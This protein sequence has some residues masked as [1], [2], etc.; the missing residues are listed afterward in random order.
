[1]KL[2]LAPYR[3]VL[4][5]F[6]FF[7]ADLL[8]SELTVRFFTLGFMAGFPGY[9]ILFSISIAFIFATIC[10]AL[11]P[12]ARKIVSF[13]ISSLAFII[14]AVQLVYH[15]FCDAFMS[16]AQIGMGGAALTTFGAAAFLK[17]LESLGGLILLILP[18][19][20]LI[21]LTKKGK[22]TGEKT[23]FK[24]LLINVVLFFAL[25]F[26][27]VLCLPIVGTH[28]YSPFDIYHDTFVLEKS[29]K[30][31][32][33]LSTLRLEIRTI[34]F[35]SSE[36]ELI[37][38]PPVT[39]E[40]DSSQTSEN[41]QTSEITE[42]TEPYQ[43]EE[44]SPEEKYGLNQS[45]IDFAKLA[46]S[47][48]DEDIKLLHTYFD[49]IQPTNKNEYTGMFEG[50]NLILIN[51]ESFSHHVIDEER[52]PMLYKMM[53]EGFIFTDYYNTICD[54]TSNGEY[55]LLT[56]LIPDTSLLGKGWKT[57]YN[58]NSSTASKENLLP[59]C[60]GNQFESIG[61]DA[62]AIHNH[63]ASYYGRNKTHP[64]MGYEFI[65]FKQ[66]LKVVDTYPTSDVSMMEQALP[67]LLEP[68]ENGEIEQFH[69]YFLTFS[70]HM[71][72]SFSEEYNDIAAK[73]AP[74]VA[75]LSYSNK[76][77]AYVACQLE[78]EFAVEYLVEQLEAAGVLDKT[79]I[80][81]TN[82]HYPYPLGV[83]LLGELAEEELDPHF[84]K[85]RSKF[86]LWSP[87]IK[88]PIIVDEPCCSLDML[89][90]LSNLMGIEYESRLLAGRD[91]FSDAEPIANLAD[92][93]FVTEKV[94]YNCESDEVI[95]RDGIE[96][97][98]EGYIE[99][100]QII[101]KNHFTASE[102]ILYKDYYRLLYE[103]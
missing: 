24:L 32:G 8:L 69:A 77:R 100:L 75:D 30:N 26:G 5:Y 13:V 102:E 38:L 63:T 51:C 79:L 9:V 101:V 76:V 35:G 68:N 53:T 95:L 56:G 39:T 94:F 31:F 97:L 52:T 18:I 84:D 103:E 62:Y 82:D 54:N 22:P 98:P 16:I 83:E 61:V 90:T 19:I 78:L 88:E 37:I 36:S 86:L 55:A 43:T 48:V 15:R 85:Y 28:I 40:S 10:S 34:F 49:T 23:S 17:T 91:I 1:M 87:S 99:N 2:K 70:G 80:A 3:L 7:F 47:S 92:R 71:P 27:V 60:L 11:K 66:G 64:N 73:N 20:A 33:I 46:A 72:Y 41:S 67:M 74:L 81:L 50:Y 29:I 57:F 25:H 4:F 45:D 6:C 12:K 65:A 59:F 58:Y 96:E 44:I 14:Y 89:P 42:S 93:S 21:I